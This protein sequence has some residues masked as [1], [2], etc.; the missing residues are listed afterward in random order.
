MGL[1]VKSGLRV[2]LGVG[3]GLH[4]LLIIPQY[5]HYVICMHTATKPAAL[6]V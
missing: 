2:G 3:S 5:H 1:R 6:S 4:V